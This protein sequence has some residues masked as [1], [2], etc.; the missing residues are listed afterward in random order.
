MLVLSPRNSVRDDG[1]LV[2]ESEGGNDIIYSPI[3]LS[4]RHGAGNGKSDRLVQKGGVVVQ[5]RD[6]DE[7]WRYT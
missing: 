3:Q 7:G 4:A 2:A 5:R 1:R 6:V